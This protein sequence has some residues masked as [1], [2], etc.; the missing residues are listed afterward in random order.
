MIP[1]DS[2]PKDIVYLEVLTAVIGGG[3]GKIAV[4]TRVAVH[5]IIAR[6]IHPGFCLPLGVRE[7]GQHARGQNIRIEHPETL[8]GMT[9]G[10]L[11]QRSRLIDIG[12]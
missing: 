11:S 1:F 12:T 8:D 6:K 10:Q 5:E 9:R 2:V 3:A 7:M 4:G